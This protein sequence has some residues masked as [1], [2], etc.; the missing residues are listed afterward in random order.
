MCKWLTQL[1]Y[2]FSQAK[3]IT[4]NISRMMKQ[5][6]KHWKQMFIII[7]MKLYY[8]MLHNSNVWNDRKIWPVVGPRHLTKLSIF[9]FLIQLY[10]K[11]HVYR[12]IPSRKCIHFHAS[13]S[14][15]TP[16]RS[17]LG[18]WATTVSWQLRVSIANRMMLLRWLT[19]STATNEWIKITV[20]SRHLCTPLKQ[21]WQFKERLSAAAAAAAAAVSRQRYTS[22]MCCVA[23]NSTLQPCFTL[24]IRYDVKSRMWHLFAHV[25]AFRYYDLN[26]IYI[27]LGAFS[28]HG[29][30]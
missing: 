28:I 9:S 13:K 22:C 15:W 14:G 1:H 8:T 7:K 29:F 19:A 20:K 11:T 6:R 10:P 23:S 25:R 5:R 24:P 2:N 30:V 4:D 12:A 21:Y 3:H 27:G 16:T 26:M 17:M 18:Q